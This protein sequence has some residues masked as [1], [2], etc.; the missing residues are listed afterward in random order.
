L[1][2]TKS[3]AGICLSPDCGVWHT[4]VLEYLASWQ[5]QVRPVLWNDIKY[6]R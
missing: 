1:R 3:F 6:E 4:S 5:I 2:V